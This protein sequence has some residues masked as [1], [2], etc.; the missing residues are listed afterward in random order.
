MKRVISVGFPPISPKIEEG[1]R[2][3]EVLYKGPTAN[4]A[5]EGLDASQSIHIKPSINVKRRKSK[6]FNKPQN[7]S[8][9]P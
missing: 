6:W 7:I 1:R 5:F 2:A 9:I 8:Q 4:F 3:L